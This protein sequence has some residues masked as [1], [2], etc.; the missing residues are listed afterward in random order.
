[1]T[2]YIIT[3]AR[4]RIKEERENIAYR[5]ECGQVSS[6]EQYRYETGRLAGLKAADEIL[7]DMERKL[8]QE[9][10]D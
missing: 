6:F 9:D 2:D 3:Y 5:L 7:L 10:E 4:D 1:M 8:D